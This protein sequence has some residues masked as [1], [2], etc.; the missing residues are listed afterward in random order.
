MEAIHE[1]MTALHRDGVNEEELAMARE[2]V[3]SSF[4]FGLENITSRMFN[5]GKNKLLLDRVI[6]PDETLRTYDAVTA[7]DIANAVGLLCPSE[8]FCGAAVTGRDFDLEALI[9]RES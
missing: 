1:E 5:L 8:E 7:E 2:Q 9:R 6:D 3:K 4:I